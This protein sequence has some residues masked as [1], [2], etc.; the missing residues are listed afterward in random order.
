MPCYLHT[1]GCLTPLNNSRWKWNTKRTELH[2]RKRVLCFHPEHPNVDNR[3]VL[4]FSFLR[5][6]CINTPTFLMIQE[7]ARIRQNGVD[8]V[9]T[10]VLL[11]VIVLVTVMPIRRNAWT[12]VQRGTMGGIVLRPA[13]KIVEGRDHVNVNQ[14]HALVDVKRN[15][16][17][18]NV[19]KVFWYR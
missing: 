4:R 3:N 6:N 7:A 15:G 13:P 11:P 14:D 10:I 5:I 12:I 8:C 1:N 19:C 9:T 17:G 2:K 18:I 16:L